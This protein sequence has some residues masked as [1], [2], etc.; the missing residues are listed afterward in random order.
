MHFTFRLNH[1]GNIPCFNWLASTWTPKFSQCFSLLCPTPNCS[2]D[3]HSQK[4]FSLP[5]GLRICISMEL[6]FLLK[7]YGTKSKL[8]AHLFTTGFHVSSFKVIR[9]IPEPKKH[10]VAISRPSRID[11]PVPRCL[12]G[13]CS[14]VWPTGNTDCFHARYSSAGTNKNFSQKSTLC[15]GRSRLLDVTAL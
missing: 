15:A 3:F 6:T 8:L 7:A 5:A 14:R 9:K 1:S 10:G 13:K 4:F 11:V 12:C 2:T